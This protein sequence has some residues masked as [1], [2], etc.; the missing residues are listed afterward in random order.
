M[1]SDLQMPLNWFSDFN[2][3]STATCESFSMR[4]CE[5]THQT[6]TD[7]APLA[8]RLRQQLRRKALM[9]LGRILCYELH[10]K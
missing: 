6:D 4:S 8:L 1:R 3:I 5:R 2:D 9:T 10:L 7:M